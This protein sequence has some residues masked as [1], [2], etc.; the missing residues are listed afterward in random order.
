M[1]SKT[2]HHEH[3]QHT[4]QIPTVG[5][6]VHFYPFGGGDKVWAAIVTAVTLYR[7]TTFSPRYSSWRFHSPG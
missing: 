3:K 2:E 5:R 6:I 7:I 1:S 4:E